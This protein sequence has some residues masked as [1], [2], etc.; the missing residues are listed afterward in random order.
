MDWEAWCNAIHG[1]TE[2][3]TTERLNWSDVSC[4]YILEM[5]PLSVTSFTNIFFHSIHCL[6]MLF[7]VSW[8]QLL[9]TVCL[10]CLRSSPEL[11]FLIC[12]WGGCLLLNI[13]KTNTDLN[14]AFSP[15]ERFQWLH[16]VGVCHSCGYSIVSFDGT[17]CSSFLPSL[18][19]CES[20]G[21]RQNPD[22]LP[23]AQKT[24]YTFSPPSERWDWTNRMFPSG[25][26][27]LRVCWKNEVTVE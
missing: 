23:G 20:V 4:L 11:Y 26:W 7:M 24:R 1:V 6:F 18:S 8:F 16:V 17:S 21:R 2:S 22:F 13:E 9:M 10:A 5:N 3:D 25:L 27:L 14:L 15:V 19:P 12:K